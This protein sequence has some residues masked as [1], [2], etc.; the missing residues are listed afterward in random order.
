MWLETV[1]ENIIEQV[2][3]VFLTNVLVLYPLQTLENQRFFSALE[4]YKMIALVRSGLIPLSHLKRFYDGWEEDA[5]P[6]PRI[7]F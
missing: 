4:G 5:K 1:S 6:F 2:V 3:N 7:L